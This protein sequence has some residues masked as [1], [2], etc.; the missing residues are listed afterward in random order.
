MSAQEKSA[1][2]V[3]SQVFIFFLTKMM[4]IAAAGL[5]LLPK[6]CFQITIIKNGK[7]RI[8]FNAQNFSLI[9]ESLSLDDK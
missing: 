5:F 3:S 4:M 8:K 7:R 1:K 2:A 9:T 6:K